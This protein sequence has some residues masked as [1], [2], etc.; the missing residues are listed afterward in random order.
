MRAPAEWTVG[1]LA[2]GV[3]ANPKTVRYYGQ[4]GLLP[5]ARR[6]AAGYRVHGTAERDRLDFILKASAAFWELYFL[7]RS[8]YEK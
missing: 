7:K 8:S 3:G 6:T 4:V 1:E 2:A 5:A